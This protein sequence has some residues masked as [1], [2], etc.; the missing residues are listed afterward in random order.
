MNKISEGTA[1]AHRLLG[2]FHRIDTSLLEHGET[3]SNHG[4]IMQ[5]DMAVPDKYDEDDGEPI[6]WGLEA[7]ILFLCGMGCMALIMVAILGTSI[8]V[9]LG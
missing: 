8:F 5:I 3:R 1:S 4:N 7:V 2:Q 6:S 9:R